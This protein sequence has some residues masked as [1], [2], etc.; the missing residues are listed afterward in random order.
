[1]M[2]KPASRHCNLRKDGCE[3]TAKQN[4]GEDSYRPQGYVPTDCKCKYNPTYKL[5][6]NL[7]GCAGPKSMNIL[8]QYLKLHTVKECDH[9]CTMDK[10]KTCKSFA[11][12]RRDGSISGYCSLYNDYCKIN[13]HSK[14]NTYITSPKVYPS[15]KISTCT[16][17]WE[18]SA[19]KDKTDSCAKLTSKSECIK[20]TFCEFTPP[21]I[22]KHENKRCSTP[23]KLGVELTKMTADTCDTACIKEEQ[24]T[25]F[26]LGEIGS[27][28]EG[29]C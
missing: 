25:E 2:Y 11:V 14:W 4:I 20:I 27:V 1:M 22:I 6:F 10:T 18:F 19:D 24:C 26:A 17:K 28:L 3:P 7:S 21:Y 13:P 5:Q 23:Q 8:T 12:G 9:A 16:H 15:T 29:R